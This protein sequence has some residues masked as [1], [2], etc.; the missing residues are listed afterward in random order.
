MKI[1]VGVSNRHIHLCKEDADILFGENYGAD[2]LGVGSNMA[3]SIR[4]WLTTANLIE[5]APSKGAK[6]SEIGKEIFDFKKIKV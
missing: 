2:E 4:Y 6:L 5:D 3:K 1:M